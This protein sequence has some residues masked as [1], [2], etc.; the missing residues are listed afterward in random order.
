MKELVVLGAQESGVG[1]AR[2]AQ[3]R[4]LRMCS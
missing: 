1:A 2:L 3:L 4:G